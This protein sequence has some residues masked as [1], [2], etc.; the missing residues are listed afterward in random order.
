[1]PEPCPSPTDY[2]EL[3][4][5]H[6]ARSALVRKLDSEE[7]QEFEDWCKANPER[8]KQLTPLSIALHKDNP[9]LRGLDAAQFDPLRSAQKQAVPDQSSGAKA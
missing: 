4:P 9:L 7:A 3:P 8:A 6:P 5:D 1:M 2:V